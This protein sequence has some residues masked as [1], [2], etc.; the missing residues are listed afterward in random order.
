MSIER[1]LSRHR[2]ACFLVALH[3]LLVGA[4]AWI[5]LNNAWNDTKPT[6]LVWVAFR[7]FDY[8][9]H[10]ILHPFIDNVAQT[11][12][13]LVATLVLGGA[14]WFAIGTLASHVFRWVGRLPIWRRPVHN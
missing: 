9:I 1:F 5:E 11:G 2:F 12:T 6:M 3:T 8:P 14:F 4:W 10:L 13:Y 7:M